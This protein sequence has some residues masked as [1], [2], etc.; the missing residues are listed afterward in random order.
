MKSHM[1]SHRNIGGI[2]D[3]IAGNLGGSGGEDLNNRVRPL[4]TPSMSS[5]S[6][7]CTVSL[8]D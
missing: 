2:I 4:Q 5:S 7:L 8:I 3:G 1:A 6:T